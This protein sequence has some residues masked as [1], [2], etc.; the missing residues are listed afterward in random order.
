[1]DADFTD[2][3]VV[4]LEDELTAPSPNNPALRYV[5]LK[6]SATPPPGWQKAFAQ[7]RKIARHAKWRNII[8]DRKFLV[9][10]CI[11]QE[12]ETHHLRDIKQDIAYANAE[13]R[14]YLARQ[15]HSENQGHQTQS[16]ERERLREM[17]SRLNFD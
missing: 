1:M 13:Y 12:I 2:I 9:V 3:K 4:S 10:E 8:V 6:L 5:Y 16:L 11:P 7:S 15:Y 14:K 17:K